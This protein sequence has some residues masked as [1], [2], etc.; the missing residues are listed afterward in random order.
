MVGHGYSRSS[1][2][3]CVYFQNTSDRL[4]IYLLLYVDDMLIAARDK[5][6]INKFKAQLSNEFTM[7][8]LGPDKKIL[9]ME[10]TKIFKLLDFFYHRESML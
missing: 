8:D 5:Y 10:I 7:K 3:N 4:Y 6:V 1:Y 9:G 2:D